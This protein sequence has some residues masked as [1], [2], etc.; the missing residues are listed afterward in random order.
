MEGKESNHIKTRRKSVS[1]LGENLSLQW[2]APKNCC[3]TRAHTGA[4]DKGVWRYADMDK[5]Q[6]ESHSATWTLN[7]VKFQEYQNRFLSLQFSFLNVC[8][9]NKY[10]MNILIHK[11]ILSLLNCQGYFLVEHKTMVYLIINGIL[12]FNK[13]QY[14]RHR[15]EA[16]LCTWRAPSATDHGQAESLTHYTCQ[17]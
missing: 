10:K 14:F 11:S 3:T 15:G 12:R 7:W 4:E 17:R 5:S 16:V 8:S 13:T 9:S 2:R 6:S 1:S